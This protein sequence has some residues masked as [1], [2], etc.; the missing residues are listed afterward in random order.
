LQLLVTAYER[1]GM[2]DLAA[3]AR[4]VLRENYGVESS[5]TAQL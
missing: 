3:D 1:V 4:S 2:R 5:S